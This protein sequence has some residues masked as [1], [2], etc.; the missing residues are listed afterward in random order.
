MIISIRIVF[1]INRP[2]TNKPYKDFRKVSLSHL[3]VPRELIKKPLRSLHMTFWYWQPNTTTRLVAADELEFYLLWKHWL[4]QGYTYR[5]SC[6]CRMMMMRNH[7]KGTQQSVYVLSV[8]GFG[9]TL[10]TISFYMRAIIHQSK[11]HEYYINFCVYMEWNVLL[12]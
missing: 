8:W 9:C 3:F 5:I 12:I 10:Y 6:V 4:L 11:D 1:D 7:S 2:T